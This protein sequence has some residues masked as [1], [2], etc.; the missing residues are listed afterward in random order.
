MLQPV[1]EQRHGLA[2]E[3]VERR[4]VV[5]VQVALA[6][7]PGGMVSRCMQMPFEPTV[8]AAMPQK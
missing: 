3:H 5:L 6:R 4:L 1:A 8:S 7:P 2:V